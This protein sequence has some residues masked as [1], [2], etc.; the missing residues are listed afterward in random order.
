MSTMSD[1]FYLHRPSELNE[2]GERWCV[3]CDDLWGCGCCGGDDPHTP[4]TDGGFVDLGWP[5]PTVRQGLPDR[6]IL[7]DLIADLRAL[8]Q[9]RDGGMWADDVHDVADRA[10]ARLR[11]VTA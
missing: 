2:D 11:E 10:E 5:C 8:N 4:H 7:L 1:T 3:Y 9:N 6:A